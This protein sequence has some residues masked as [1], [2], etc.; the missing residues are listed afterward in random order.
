MNPEIVYSL[1]NR[2][3][4]EELGLVVECNNPKQLSFYL[5][6]AAKDLEKYSPLMVTI[7]STPDTVIIVKKTVELDEDV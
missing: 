2:A 3:L 1:L 4:S 7:P 6:E 5:L